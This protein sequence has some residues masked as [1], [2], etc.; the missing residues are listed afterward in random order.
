MPFVD[1]PTFKRRAVQPVECLKRG[2]ELIKDKYWLF[3]GMCAVAMLVGG[4]VPLGILMGPMMCGVYLCLFKQIRGESVDF[5]ILFKGFDYFVQSLIATLVH[6]VPIIALLL[7]FYL[8]FFIGAIITPENPRDGS[9]APL[10][11]FG[12]MMVALLMVFVLVIVIGVLFTFAYSL[13]VDRKLNGIDAVKLSFRGALANFWGLLA[14]MFLNGVLA[15]A[16]LL[17]CYVGTFLVLPI[18][19]A[20]IAVAYDQVFGVMTNSSFPP[21][22]P[23]Q[24]QQSPAA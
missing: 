23:P 12:A 14:L 8:L 21:P 1:L 5:S 15:F 20:G 17:L 11:F 19:F 7:P 4:S 16:G 22:P 18:S 6:M 9:P 2:Y 3:V 10:I 13:I 24:F